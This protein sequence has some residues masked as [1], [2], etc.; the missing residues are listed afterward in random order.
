MFRRKYQKRNC[1]TAGTVESLRYS[2][3]GTGETKTI[4]RTRR[5]TRQAAKGGGSGYHGHRPR[6]TLGGLGGFGFLRN[7]FTTPERVCTMVCGVTKRR[8]DDPDTGPRKKR[9]RTTRPII[10]MLLHVGTEKKPV[11]ALLDTGC[12]IALINQQTV[13]RWGIQK[14]RHKEARTIESFTGATVQGAGQHY[15]EPLCLQHRKYFT[16]EVFEISPMEEGIDVFLPFK[17]IERH[18]PQGAWDTEE[19]RFNSAGCLEN[20]NKFATNDF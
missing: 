16:R 18:P 2:H 12:S 9:R 15:T 8:P 13:K 1:A 5:P 20:C 7:S 4:G 6:E 17:W 3:N 19:I 11:K 10:N 14:R